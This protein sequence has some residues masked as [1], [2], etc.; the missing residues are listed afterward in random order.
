MAQL[1]PTHCHSCFLGVLHAQFPPVAVPITKPEAH[2]LGAGRFRADLVAWIF[3]FHLLL[4]EM[5]ERSSQRRHV[6][7]MERHVIECLRSR[8]AFEQRDRDTVVAYGDALF[9]LEL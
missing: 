9:E 3:E 5:L 1:S 7:Q 2:M 8:L 6:R 4:L